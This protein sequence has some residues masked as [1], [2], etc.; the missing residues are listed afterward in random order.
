M[1]TEREIRERAIEE[2]KHDPALAPILNKVISGLFD[3]EP[4]GIS[5]EHWALLTKDTNEPPKANPDPQ[6]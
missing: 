6:A 4:K 3:P 2:I 1:P 5:I